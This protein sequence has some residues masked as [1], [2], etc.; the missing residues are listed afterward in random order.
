MRLV[1]RWATIQH[2]YLQW[3]N[4]SDSWCGNIKLKWHDWTFWLIAPG[5]RHHLTSP[6]LGAQ[7]KESDQKMYWRKHLP[8]PGWGWWPC[9]ATACSHH[10]RHCRPRLQDWTTL[11]TVN[12]P[13]ASPPG[14]AVNCRLTSVEQYSSKM[15]NKTIPKAGTD[16]NLGCLESRLEKQEATVEECSPERGREREREGGRGAGMGDHLCCHLP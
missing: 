1:V 6:H 12:S 7:H 14:L 4:S 15:A 8:G 13:L 16:I 11:W 10:C 3:M 9:A 5:T 2:C